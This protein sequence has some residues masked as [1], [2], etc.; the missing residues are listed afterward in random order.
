MFIETE[1]GTFIIS[2][3]VMV[4]VAVLPLT[5]VAVILAVPALT[6]V[7]L[8][9]FTVATL[10]LLLDH[11]TVL[12]VASVGLTVAVIVLDSPLFKERADVFNEIEV[13]ILSLGKTFTCTVLVTFSS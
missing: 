11:L 12:S 7:T 3:T 4:D 13:G 6:A 9:L 2:F 8:P 5:V 10:L 1:V